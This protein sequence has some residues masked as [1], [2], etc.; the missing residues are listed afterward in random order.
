MICKCKTQGSENICEICVKLQLH[1]RDIRCSGLVT[2]DFM[3][4]SKPFSLKNYVRSVRTF[5]FSKTLKF[6]I[7]LQYVKPIKSIRSSLVVN[8]IP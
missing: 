8:L 1:K 7:F 3:G 4:F 2:L 6:F 5:A